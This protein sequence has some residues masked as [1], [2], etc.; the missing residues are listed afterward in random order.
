[1]NKKLKMLLT[2]ALIVSLMLVGCGNAKG[3]EESAEAQTSVEESTEVKDTLIVATTY[4]AKSLDPHATNDVASSNVMEQIYDTLVKLNDKNEVI[5]SLAEKFE[6]VDAL[7]YRFELKKGVKFHNGEELKASDVEYTFRRAISPMGGS[8]AHI[9]GD[10]DPDG[11]EIIDD[12]TIIIKTKTPNSAFLPSLTHKGGGV[13]LNQKAVEAAGDSYSMNPVGTGPFKFKDWAKGNK[14]TLERFDDYYGEAPTFKTLVIRAIPEA[15]NRTIEL[16]SGGVD[17]AYDITTND[18]K[19]VEE[20]KDLNLIRKMGNS[21]TYFAFNT[22]KPPYDDERVRQAISLAIDTETIVNAVF[23]GVGAPAEGAVPPNIKYFN[24]ELGSPEYDVEKAKALLAEAGYPEG[25][26]AVI[27]TN[28]KK[29]RVD[30]STIIQNQLGEIGI[31]VEIQVLEW[32]A[33]LEG[34]KNGEHQMFMVGW[35]TQT[36]DPDMS[37][38]GP[39]HSS[40][41]G[42]NN[43]SYYDNKKVDDLLEEGRQ[44]ADS[45]ERQAVYEEL[46]S[47]IRTEAPWIVMNNGEIVVGVRSN[48]ENFNPSPFGYHILY[49]VN[50]K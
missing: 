14:I 3:A 13:I 5:G 2:S 39:F 33:Y 40:Q 6:A 15:T 10:I 46:Q 34:I 8:I 42:K 50:I 26:K 48:I 36:P 35:S 16:E 22:Q 24:K 30:M 47:I 25:F 28:E 17:I 7:T 27:W 45:P 41:K 32:G 44:L 19:R 9:V 29:A 11:F 31:D 49:N 18:I 21:T 23:R 1:M 4:D 43:F 38:F 37:L 12:Y 20:N